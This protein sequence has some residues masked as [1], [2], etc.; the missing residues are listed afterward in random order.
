MDRKLNTTR[1]AA[2]LSV[3]LSLFVGPVAAEEPAQNVYGGRA[4]AYRNLSAQSLENVSTVDAIKSAAMASN[5]SPT[6]L[7]RVLE[8]GEKV[9]C[10]DCIVHVAKLLYD[11]HPK[12]REISAWWLRRRIFG[13][14]G[15]GEV[16]SQVVAT[17]GDAT[18]PEAKRAYAASALGEFLIGT[19]VKPVATA[20]VNDASPMVRES[21]AR[22]LRRLNSEGPNA[23]LARAIA[24]DDESVRLAALDAAVH[25]H[26]F[27]G[28]DA[29]VERIS[30]ASP[31]VRRRAAQSLGVMRVGDAVMGLIALS[32]AANEPDPSVRAAAIAALG[33]IADPASKPAV[34]AALEDEAPFVRD[35]ARVALRRL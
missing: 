21:A 5:V 15:P 29:I 4:E 24:D 35:A 18:A 16:Y 11:A 31:L 10:L 23:E 7:W 34:Q 13:V 6:K 30:D 22:A 25:I 1:L 12:T 8:H 14:F 19:G 17:L 3:S 33:K 32:S 9:E 27:S 20:L 26:A 2:L 28:V